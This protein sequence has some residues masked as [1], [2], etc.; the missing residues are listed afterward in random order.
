MYTDGAG[1]S[2][3]GGCNDEQ[4]QRNGQSREEAEGNL[5]VSFFRILFLLFFF[6][7]Y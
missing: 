3:R 1:G 5:L 2:W 7:L 6:Y 4:V